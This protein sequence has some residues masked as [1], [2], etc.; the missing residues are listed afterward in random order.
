[1]TLIFILFLKH[2]IIHTAS[3]D[4]TI[5][6]INFL[7]ENQQEFRDCEYSQ[8]ELK[9]C[10]ASSF[11]IDAGNK[12][13]SIFQSSSHVEEQTPFISTAEK[14]SNQSM[15]AA[16]PERIN[17][18][19]NFP[20]K[21]RMSNDG[22]ISSNNAKIF[23]K[24][25][26]QDQC[27][28]GFDSN[29]Q[30]FFIQ[31]AEMRKSQEKEYS[32]IQNN[33]VIIDK[34]VKINTELDGK[35]IQKMRKRDFNNYINRCMAESTIVIHGFIDNLV[36]DLGTIFN[37]NFLK[38]L[39]YQ[40]FENI[41]MT[42]N[43]QRLPYILDKVLEENSILLEHRNLTYNGREYYFYEEEYKNLGFCVICPLFQ[44]QIDGF[45]WNLNDEVQSIRKILPHKFKYFTQMIIFELNTIF[46][47]LLKTES[48]Q[49]LFSDKFFK[50]HTTI[51]QFKLHNEMHNLACHSK[52]KL[53]YRLLH[54]Q[55]HTFLQ[56]HID[57][58]IKLFPEFVSIAYLL[59]KKDILDKIGYHNLFIV[60][61]YSITS[62]NLFFDA[63]SKNNEFEILIQDCKKKN[64]QFIL[65]SISF[66][67]RIYYI[68]PM[69][70]CLNLEMDTLLRYSYL[71][72]K[73]FSN[74]IK[75]AAN[76]YNNE[77][78]HRYLLNCITIVLCLNKDVSSTY[79]L[80]V[81]KDDKICHDRYESVWFDEND[82]SKFRLFLMCFRKK[83]RIT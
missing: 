2:I 39:Q 78:F 72:R 17:S 12:C 10:S 80:K 53:K 15:H 32:S 63:I 69:I 56:D 70:T 51:C 82:L 24:Q 1:M 76:M 58:K 77:K 7:I 34:Y 49:V 62:I 6:K 45:S 33:E 14:S 22:E 20:Y 23:R 35:K 19:K 60:F 83:H 68:Q 8:Y 59:H 81:F 44:M 40:S 55:I 64:N 65:Q 71:I 38:L 67:L 43:F 52:F 48:Y 27:N 13:N 42:E 4:N 9:N 47:L 26:F 41:F 37:S 50:S 79:F 11:E 31:T 28:N 74:Q 61:Y 54:S 46:N 16:M 21:K 18:T 29:E 25:D 66:L 36:F 57:N 73:E 75:S 3:F 30:E 5:N